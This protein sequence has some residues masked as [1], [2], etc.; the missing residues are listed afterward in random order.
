MFAA[1]AALLF[2]V[3]VLLFVA[4]VLLCVAAVPALMLIIAATAF[5][6]AAAALLFA[7]DCCCFCTHA[8]KSFRRENENAIFLC[9]YIIYCKLEAYKKHNIKYTRKVEYTQY[10]IC[11]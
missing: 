1:A 5:L 7:A 2:A 8:C 10:K 11:K 6:P 3:A 9:M 4:A